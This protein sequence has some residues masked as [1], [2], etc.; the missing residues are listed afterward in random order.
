MTVFNPQF[1]AVNEMYSLNTPS[2]LSGYIG[3]LSELID[4]HLNCTHFF[5]VANKEICGSLVLDWIIYLS[6]PLQYVG[7]LTWTSECNLI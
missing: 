2:A 7:I 3:L 6:L 1:F 4:D 5:L